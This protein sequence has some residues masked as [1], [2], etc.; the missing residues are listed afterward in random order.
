MASNHGAPE[1]TCGI[2]SI[3]A[4]T[5]VA[6]D[7]IVGMQADMRSFY[8][9]NATSAERYI[10]QSFAGIKF[11]HGSHSRQ[12]GPP[13]SLAVTVKQ[14]L[15]HRLRQRLQRRS[16]RKVRLLQ[17]RQSGFG[18]LAGRSA[19]PRR[20]RVICCRSS[21]RFI[22]RFTAMAPLSTCRACSQYRWAAW[23]RSLPL[24]PATLSVASRDHASASCLQSGCREIERTGDYY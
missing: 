20:M 2:N 9:P 14:A 1:K 3:P 7:I 6:A 15:Q 21:D 8:V 4:V 22:R 17:R 19:S 12:I 5:T 10:A 23:S 16:V 13:W 18:F 11:A 24:L